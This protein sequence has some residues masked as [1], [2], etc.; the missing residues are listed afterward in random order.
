MV[1]S[2]S[3]LCRRKTGTDSCDRQI[4]ISIV[5]KSGAALHRILLRTVMHAPMRFFYT[6]DSGIILNRFSQD[7]TLVDV[8][9]PTVAFGTVLCGSPVHHSNETLLFRG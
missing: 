9:L 3:R 7:M 5:P 4:M 8:V 2:L 1:A 6:T